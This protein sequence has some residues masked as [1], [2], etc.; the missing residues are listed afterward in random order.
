MGRRTSLKAYENGANSFVSKPLN[1]DV[2]TKAVRGLG[3][4]WPIINKTASNR[5][6]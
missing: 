3:L 1:I 5:D 6:D 4:Y 2:L